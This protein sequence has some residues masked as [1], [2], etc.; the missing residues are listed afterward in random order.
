VSP[1][2]G[3]QFLWKLALLLSGVVALG[4]IAIPI[5][6]SDRPIGTKLLART[7]VIGK[8]SGSGGLPW[9]GSEYQPEWKNLLGAWYEEITKE[10][11]DFGA[12]SQGGPYGGGYGKGGELTDIEVVN[13]HFADPATVSALDWGNDT[14]HLE[15]ADAAMV[16]WH[17]DVPF[18]SDLSDWDYSSY[19]GTMQADESGSGDCELRMDEMKLGN[20]GL[21]FLHFSSCHSMNDDQ[22]STWPSVYAGAHQIDGFHGLAHLNAWQQADYENFAFDAF[23]MSIADAWVDNMYRRKVDDPDNGVDQCPVAHTVGKTGPEAWERLG[24]ERYNNVLD[25]PNGTDY[26]FVTFIVPCK[27]E[28]EEE[29]DA[30]IH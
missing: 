16:G 25:E 14:A 22:W 24:L 11:S 13:S 9:C 7:Y 1:E 19:V 8:S 23:Y 30:L 5:L 21:K 15:K 12:F 29:L 27:P 20:D 2:T 18:L 4:V 17:G 10:S 3:N 6:V 28:S 26:W